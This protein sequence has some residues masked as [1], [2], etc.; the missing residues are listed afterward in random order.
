MLRNKALDL[1]RDLRSSLAYVLELTIIGIIYLAVSK[2]SLTL[3]SINP[4]ATPIWPTTGIAL[5]TVLLRGYR[6][7][8]AIFIG[9]L[10]VNATTAGSIYTSS[11]IAVGNTLESTLGAYLLDRWSCGA[12]TFDTPGGVARFTLISLF[13]STFISA[14]IGVGSLLLAGFVKVPDFLPVWMTWWMG[15][16][17]GALVIAPAI[18]LW[19]RTARPSF[20][21]HELLQSGLVYAS[22][23]AVGLIAFSPL[24]EDTPARAPLA[25]LAALPLL[26]AA[27]WRNRRDTATTA[28]LLSFFA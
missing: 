10:I 23:I 27:L 19:S 14:T 5:A 8:P 28:L 22:A 26:W 6:V 9:A 18:V 7:V 24:F 12:G 11:G 3:A 2:L 25:F 15:D 16:F 1:P 17:A 20:Q 21:P 4:S 13:P